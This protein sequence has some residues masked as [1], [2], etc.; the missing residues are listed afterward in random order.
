MHPSD[1]AD[2]LEE[3]PPQER[4]AIFVSLDEDCSSAPGAML[5]SRA[6]KLAVLIGQKKA[7]AMAVKNNRTESRYSALLPRLRGED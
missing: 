7:L 5:T 1:L 6:K 2:I 3:L 4:E